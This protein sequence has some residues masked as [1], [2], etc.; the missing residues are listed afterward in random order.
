VGPVLQFLHPYD[1]CKV[2]PLV[3]PYTG[4]TFYSF[5]CLLFLHFTTNM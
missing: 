4:I 3:F 1:P 2:P 5:W